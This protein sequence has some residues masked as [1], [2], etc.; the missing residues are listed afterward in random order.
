[1]SRLWIRDPLAIFADGAERG[2]IIEGHRIAERVAAGQEPRQSVDTIFDAS[3]HVVLPGLVNTHHHFYQ[4]LTRAVPAA[5]DATLFRW[6]KTLYP[7]WANLT[8]EAVYTSALVGL[9]VLGELAA[10]FGAWKFGS[11]HLARPA[12]EIPQG[13]TNSEAIGRILYTDNVFYFE[14]VGIILLTAIV[15]AVVLTLRKRKWVKRQ[16]I[17]EQVARTPETAI[18]IVK[19]KSGKGI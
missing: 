5:Q 8:P 16:D 10:V 14:A 9:A 11:L 13:L 7:I 6:L 1:M 17:G 2:L 18:E 3:Q 4:T 15:G 19:V 12:A